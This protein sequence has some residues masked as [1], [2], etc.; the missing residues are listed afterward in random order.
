MELSFDWFQL[1]GIVGQEHDADKSERRRFGEDEDE[2]A[3]EEGPVPE[4]S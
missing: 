2:D 1:L 4:Q 3:E